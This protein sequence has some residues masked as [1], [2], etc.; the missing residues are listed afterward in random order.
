ME[1]G[2]IAPRP[3][4][5]LE[6]VKTLGGRTGQ[7][8]WKGSDGLRLMAIVT[9]NAYEDREGETI[10][11]VALTEYVDKAW[12]A[13][14]A[15]NTENALLY[16]HNGDPIGDIIH[17]DMEGP[18]LFEI[19]KERPNHKIYL[20]YETVKAADGSEQVV[21]RHP[22]TVQ[23]IWDH[24]E[25]AQEPLGASHGFKFN[26]ADKRDGVYQ[27][28]KKFETSV[29]PLDKAANPYTFSGVLNMSSRDKHL[30]QLLGAEGAAD[31]LRGGIRGLQQT[32]QKAGLQHKSISE[33]Q[34]EVEEIAIDTKAM[35]ES[36]A[37]AVVALLPEDM[38]EP[39]RPQILASMQSYLRGAI[40]DLILTGLYDYTR[41]NLQNPIAAAI[42]EYMQGG[43]TAMMAMSEEAEG[44]MLKALDA[45]T[46]GQAE[47]LESIT[48]MEK[49]T[50]ANFQ[51]LAD[52]VKT[53]L[54]LVQTIGN[55]SDR[56]KALEG[57]VQLTPRSASKAAET[58]IKADSAVVQTIETAKTREKVSSIL[59]GLFSEED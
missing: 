2:Y 55:L 42:A 9:S 52:G 57:L 33:E 17:A 48:R 19:A 25:A 47:L 11:T 29:L 5:I 27:R 43:Q 38:R 50:D 56:V 24:L 58:V 15:C 14:D 22:T 20:T 30:D 6:R 7:V 54:P 53:L 31:K 13:G 45:A 59:P 49:A 32:L 34:D 37:D 4:T 26:K 51:T 40:S 28:I 39:M 35:G 36:L 1:T 21:R 44:K 12:A 41:S 8:I 3:L 23:A 16:W 46:E 10:T 18:F